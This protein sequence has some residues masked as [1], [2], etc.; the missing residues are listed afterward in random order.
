MADAFARAAAKKS[1]QHA[2]A[3]GTWQDKSLILTGEGVS[4]VQGGPPIKPPQIKLFE[5]FQPA[6]GIYI[7]TSDTGVG[8]TATLMGLVM[9]ANAIGIPATYVSVF[10]PRET[11]GADE[12]F[13]AGKQFI[14]ALEKVVLKADNL[15]ILAIDSITGP[16]KDF[17][18]NYPD[19]STFAGGM[20]PSDRAFLVEG[21]RKL[22]NANLVG[23]WSVN[24]RLVPYVDDLAGSTEGLIDVIAPGR[25]RFHDRTIQ[26]K[27]KK[28]A[29]INV[30]P[31]IMEEVFRQLS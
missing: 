28:G 10:E 21:A 5:E 3:A 27:R 2:A 23:F 29:T 12:H 26:S 24:K 15:R 19:Q 25:F 18:S 11:A 31:E 1:K 16:L 7:V 20:Q 17:S 30:P 4:K 9:Y 22:T 6:R 13:K 8:K 14:A